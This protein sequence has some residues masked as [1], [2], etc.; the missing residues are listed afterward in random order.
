MTVQLDGG[1]LFLGSETQTK[2]EKELSSTVHRVTLVQ[3]TSFI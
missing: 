1:P 2:I 3:A